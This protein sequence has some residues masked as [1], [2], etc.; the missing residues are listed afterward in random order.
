[1]IG[2]D[3]DLGGILC[4]GD[5]A[6][7]DAQIGRIEAQLDVQR[8][9]PVT[10]YLVSSSVT[11]EICGSDFDACYQPSDDAIYSRWHSVGHELVHATAKDLEIPSLF[12]SEGAAV[13][14]SDGTL[15]DDRIVLEPADLEAESLTT[16]RSAGHFSRYLV[17]RHGWEA[18]RRIL[19]KEP[20]EAVY[21]RS[22]ADLTAEYE[23]SAPYAYPPFEPCPYPR[24]PQVG[25]TSWH[26]AL[27]FTCATPDA[28]AF[29]GGRWGNGVAVGRTVELTA[30]TYEVLL[31]GG[32]ELFAIAC[33]DRELAVETAPPSN[34]DLY[35]E[36]DLAAALPFAANQSHR[37]VLT[38]GTYL[39]WIS[40]S[41][42]DR[43]SAEISIQRVE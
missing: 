19:R 36:V 35:N 10:I 23:R 43:V 12:W 15:R 39:L 4:Q 26:A 31:T 3:A 34:G 38:D 7:I 20:F 37:L 6:F 14:L 1:M 13:L 24:I 42:Y 30:G 41:S 28:T 27:D 21:G 2:V 29:G 9:F 8:D 33:H 18:Y 11:N 17:E 22:A 5:L 25:E 16:Y 32:E 40:G